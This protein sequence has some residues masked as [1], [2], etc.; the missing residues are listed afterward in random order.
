MVIWGTVIGQ[1]TLTQT[2]PSF[3]W[4]QR[5]ISARQH[6]KSLD[7]PVVVSVEALPCSDGGSPVGNSDAMR[8]LEIVKF[9]FHPWLRVGPIYEGSLPVSYD[10]RVCRKSKI[11][12]LNT[13]T[14]NSALIMLKIL[15]S[16]V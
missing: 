8:P 4:S 13:R 16:L 2:L 9:A 5:L 14:T 7:I 15:L 11:S 10:A 12:A 6:E 3:L 1:A